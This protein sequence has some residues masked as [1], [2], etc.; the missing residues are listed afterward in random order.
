MDPVVEVDQCAQKIYYI[1]VFGKVAA[2]FIRAVFEC[3]CKAGSERTAEKCH[4]ET[5]QAETLAKAFQ[6]KELHH[7]LSNSGILFTQMRLPHSKTAL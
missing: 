4:F 7:M 5:K 6:R 3:I 2:D 1:E